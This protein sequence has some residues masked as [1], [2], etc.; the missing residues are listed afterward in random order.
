[1]DC[2]LLIKNCKVLVGN[3]SLERNRKPGTTRKEDFYTAPSNTT[4]FINRHTHPT[5]FDD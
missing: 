5:F 3:D 1:M 4:N 2:R